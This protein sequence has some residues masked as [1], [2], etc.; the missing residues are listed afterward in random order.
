M[1]AFS[2]GTLFFQLLMT[3][4]PLALLILLLIFAWRGIKAHERIA[5]SLERLVQAKEMER[6]RETEED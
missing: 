2:M 5:A 6:K 1:M 4:L 3:L